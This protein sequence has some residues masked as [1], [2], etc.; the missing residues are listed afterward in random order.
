M[1]IIGNLTVDTAKVLDINPV[2]YLAAEA[3]T[4]NVGALLTPIASIPNIIIQGE[5]ET[6]TFGFHAVNLMPF[7][8]LL[9]PITVLLLLKYFKVLDEP[10]EERKTFLMEFSEWLVVSNRRL[11]N[12][13]AIL[14]SMMIGSFVIL[15]NLFPRVDLW[16]LA[17]FFMFTFLSLP[18]IEVEAV[19]TELDWEL[20]FFLIGLFIM[21]EGL[22]HRGILLRVAQAMKSVVGSNYILSLLVVLWFSSLASGVIDDIAVTVVLIPIVL[23]LISPDSPLQAI[24]VF[25]ITTLIISVN[26]GGNLTPMASPTTVLAMS[27]SKKTI[28]ELTPKAF[29]KIGFFITILQVGITTVYLLSVLTVTYYY[30]VSMGILNI[31]VLFVAVTLYLQLFIRRN[32]LT[33]VKAIRSRFSGFWG[34]I[35]DKWRGL[36]G[37]EK[38]EKVR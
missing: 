34:T 15:P 7:S 30:G 8:L 9:I 26:I 37:K 22:N 38:S 21:V 3:M 12:Q 24:S 19:L 6:V 18:E 5:L 31:I 10:S 11:F 33:V 36:L 35:R 29:F 32:I 16:L 28:H 13:S 17:V 27:L 2:P 25:I 20:I 14:F 4:V 1:I 23:E